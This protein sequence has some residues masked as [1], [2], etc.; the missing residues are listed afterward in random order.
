MLVSNIE[1][2]L[3]KVHFLL[4]FLCIFNWFERWQIFKKFKNLSSMLGIF[5]LTFRYGWSVF[6]HFF[7]F[8][9]YKVWMHATLLIILWFISSFCREFVRCLSFLE[10][11]TQNYYLY[12]SPFY[13][14]LCTV[15]KICT[16]KVQNVV[17]IVKKRIFIF[18]IFF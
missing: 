15:V 18:L 2:Q 1:Q 6:P 11:K 13:I 3:K 12:Y 8:F 4:H 9:F 14:Y 10:K 16:K 7:R 5:A 17:C